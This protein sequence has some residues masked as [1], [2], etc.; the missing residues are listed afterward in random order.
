[1]NRLGDL[2]AGGA[3]RVIKGYGALEPPLIFHPTEAQAPGSRRDIARRLRA[4]ASLGRVG[5]NRDIVAC[6]DLGGFP[7]PPA[8]RQNKQSVRIRKPFT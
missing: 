7:S 3:D 8:I 6:L 2:F 4:T 5:A 1:M